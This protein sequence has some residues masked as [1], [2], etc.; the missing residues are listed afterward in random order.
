MAIATR[1]KPGRLPHCIAATLL[2]ALFGFAFAAAMAQSR[3]ADRLDPAWDDRDVALTRVI[4]ALPQPFERTAMNGFG[5]LQIVR[6]R[7]RASLAEKVRADPAGAEERALLRMIE[8]T[9]PPVPRHQRVSRR[10]QAWLSARP[11][12]IAEHVALRN[13][14]ARFVRLEVFGRGELDRVRRHD[15]KPQLHRQRERGAHE[16]LALGQARALHFEVIAPGKEL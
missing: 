13:A 4:A 5:F 6:R 15:G 9:P 3:L 14:D 11:P 7:A 16:L 10:V 8:R 12:L 2:G 1:S